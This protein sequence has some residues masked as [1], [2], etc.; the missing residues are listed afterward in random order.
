MDSGMSSAMAFG[1]LLRDNPEAAHIYD[2]CTP[3]QKQQL[4]LKIQSTPADS[5]ESFVS[6]LSSAL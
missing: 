1:A 5:M 4:L 2:T 6:Q 3:Q